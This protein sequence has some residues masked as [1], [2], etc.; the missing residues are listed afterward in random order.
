M[1]TKNISAISNA[2]KMIYDKFDN[3]EVIGK[4]KKSLGLISEENE[5]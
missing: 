4:G 3:E 2:L 5:S 1:M